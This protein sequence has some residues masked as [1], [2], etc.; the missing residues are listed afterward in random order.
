VA[1]EVAGDKCDEQ[2]RDLP[3]DCRS[4]TWPRLSAGRAEPA[5]G[6]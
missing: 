4:R 2:P 5:S 1:G 6:V 3:N